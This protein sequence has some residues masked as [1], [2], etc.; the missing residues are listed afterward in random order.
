MAE[1]EVVVNTVEDEE[2]SASVQEAS[3]KMALAWLGALS[4]VQDVLADCASKC[5]DRGVEVEQV[6]R[7]RVRERMEQ[8]KHQVR[9][10]VQ[11]QRAEVEAVEDDLTGE[12]E[13]ILATMDVPSKSDIETLTAK[14]TELS[15]KVDE[16]KEA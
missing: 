12:V 8:R 5:V 14:V 13:G 6:A 2:E 9:K 11:R 16:L 7:R 15:K 10:V 3:R 4:M 1:V